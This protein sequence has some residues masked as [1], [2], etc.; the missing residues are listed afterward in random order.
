MIVNVEKCTLFTVIG[1]AAIL[2]SFV[3]IKKG[4]LKNS[5]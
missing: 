5:S 2:A 3:I 4:A 1:A